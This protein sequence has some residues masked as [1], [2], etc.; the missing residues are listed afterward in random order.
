MR[1]TFF[2]D[3]AMFSW[4]DVPKKGWKMYNS[5][6]E[7]D[8]GK[9]IFSGH[10]TFP[11]RYGWLKKVFDV[12]SDAESN[13]LDA[14]YVFNSPE[15]ISSFGV[16]KNMVSSMRHWAVHTGVLSNNKLTV[17]A[18][19]TF[20]DEGIDPWMEN[21]TTLW[22]IHWTLTRKSNLITYYW[23]FNYYNG[24]MFDRKLINDEI[25]ELCGHSGWKKPS[26]ITLKRDV[27]CF[28][29]MYAGKDL[30][31][32]GFRDDSIESPL[33]ELSLIKSLNKHGF[34]NPNRGSK[35]SLS[36][37][38]FMLAVATFWEEHSA[39]SASLSL[40]ALLYD[41]KSPGRIFLL[42]EAGLLEKIHEASSFLV[43][44]VSWSETAGMRQ[45]TKVAG[46]K[47]SKLKEEASNL[48]KSEYNK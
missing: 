14:K 10:E 1:L 18:Y 11:L 4:L 44:K 45:F 12:V 36:V 13:S 35:A 29:R 21:P 2:I 15:S 6:H 5:M 43:G 27:E 26:A 33:S 28:V 22:K 38:M 34:F 3:I 8:S 41:P 30:S 46:F 7:I 16:G 20:S 19:D 47:L 9:A 48:I 32:R 42:D 39:S 17:E 23:F 40:E 31:V 25:L 37:G 24:G